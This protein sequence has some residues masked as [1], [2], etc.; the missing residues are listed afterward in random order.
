MNTFWK[1]G[2]LSYLY[3]KRGVQRGLQVSVNPGGA[4]VS[5][6]LLLAGVGYIPPPL[7]NFRT[8]RR[9]EE[10]EETIESSQRGDSDAILQFSQ[11]SSIGSMSGQRSKPARIALSA[12][13]TIPETAE[14]P[15][16]AKMLLKGRRRC[17]VSKRLVLSTGQGQGQV[18]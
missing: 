7:S 15:N 14:S 18:K 9:S 16:L 6:Q 11:Q 1:A 5:S 13:E 17:H 8:N 4:G 3:D 12:A 2:V 10:R